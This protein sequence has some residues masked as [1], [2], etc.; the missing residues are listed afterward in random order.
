MLE[1]LDIDPESY[2]PGRI[3]QPI[4][5]FRLSCIE[6]PEV[7]ISY[8]RTISYGI[9]RCEFDEYLLR[10]CGARI[11]EGL[12]FNS[13]ERTRGGWLVNNEIK[14]RLVVGAGGHFCP[15]SRFLGNK[16]ASPSVVA[17]E[18]EFEMPAAQAASCSIAGELPSSTFAA[19]CAATDGVSANR[20]S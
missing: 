15:V 6:E 12:P 17:R 13:I 20:M 4:T 11:R 7:D 5:G 18:I 14:A 10:R 8:G 9:L 1:A 2:G 19:T 16:A 3:L